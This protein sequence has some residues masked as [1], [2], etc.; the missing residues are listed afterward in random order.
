[1]SKITSIIVMRKLKSERHHILSWLVRII[2][3]DTSQTIFL[4]AK[5]LFLNGYLSCH[6]F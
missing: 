4:A 3:E 6:D 2:L 5:N 1:M